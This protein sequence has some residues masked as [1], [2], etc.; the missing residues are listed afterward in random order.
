MP[1]KTVICKNSA[2]ISVFTKVHPEHISD[3]TFQSSCSGEY[4]LVLNSDV[5]IRDDILER[6]VHF[7]R[8]HPPAGAA[9]ASLFFPDG[10]RQ[11]IGSDVYPLAYAF[12]DF[13]FLGKLFSAR[14]RRRREH[15]FYAGWDR[16]SSRSVEVLPDSFFLLRRAALPPE[17]PL[18][19]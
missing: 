4:F 10:R 5:E 15:V 8:E 7:L 17:T 13:T 3:L 6:L 18:Y 14:A 9:G 2:E 1:G 11:L 16:A 12:L 19:D